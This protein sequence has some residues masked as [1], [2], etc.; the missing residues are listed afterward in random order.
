MSS[1]FMSNSAVKLSDAS[2]S[3]CPTRVEMNSPF[4]LVLSGSVHM[5]QN[6]DSFTHD[7]DQ[8]P[9]MHKSSPIDGTS[10]ESPAVSRNRRLLFDL[11]GTDHRKVSSGSTGSLSSIRMVL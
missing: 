4:Q 8:E 3:N 10:Q 11:Q 7:V 2:S 6:N 5:V 9:A 1:R